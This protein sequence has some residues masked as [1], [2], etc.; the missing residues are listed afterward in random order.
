VV[1]VLTVIVFSVLAV[2]A[3]LLSTPCKLLSDKV[4]QMDTLDLVQSLAIII[5]A[6]ALIV[7][8]KVTR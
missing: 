8:I 4:I 6:L 3:L 5:V 2:I 1:N 7:H